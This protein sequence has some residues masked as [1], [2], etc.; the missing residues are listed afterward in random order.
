M[1]DN[2][3]PRWLRHIRRLEAIARAGLT[4]AEGPFDQQR[5]RE[6]ESI[7]ASLVD[8]LCDVE[9][10]HARRVLGAEPGY[11]TPKVD[12]RG[13]AFREGRVLLVR[14]RTDGLWTLP[15]GWADIGD[16]PSEILAREVREES[17]FDV[18]V[19]KLAALWDR[20]GQGHPPMAHH[21]YKAFFLCEITGGEARPSV[22]TSEV[23]F[24][25]EDD[26]PDLSLGR[27]LPGQIR[28][29]FA[30]HRDPSRP[31]EFD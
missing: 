26:L 11:A 5:Y 23:A 13:A 7:T 19:T 17:G 6:L 27:V 16:T 31:T 10:G 12:V 14:E 2:V 21:V 4:Y 1:E 28:R 24:F 18:R 20:D 3:T 30:H 25:A 8:A 22:E 15:G 29:M 9:P